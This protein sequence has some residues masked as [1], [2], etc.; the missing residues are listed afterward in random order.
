MWLHTRQLYSCPRYFLLL[1]S[2]PEMSRTN[3]PLSG[4]IVLALAMQLSGC[5]KPPE[6]K[7]EP[8][9]VPQQV[10]EKPKGQSFV[11]RAAEQ[12]KPS[13]PSTPR[14]IFEA[15]ARPSR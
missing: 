10:P 1:Q 14:Q 13:P 3:R 15:T 11:P 4:V 9:P 6:P 7:P 8:K 12:I 2:R 5:K